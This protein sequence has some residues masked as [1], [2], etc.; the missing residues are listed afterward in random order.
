MNKKFVIVV[1]AALVA[2]GAVVALASG[3][4]MDDLFV[5]IRSSFGGGETV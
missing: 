3:G 1:L 5:F 4:M 2:V